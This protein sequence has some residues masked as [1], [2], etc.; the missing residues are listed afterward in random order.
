MKYL[1][2][3]QLCS[4]RGNSDQKEKRRKRLHLF[5]KVSYSTSD[6]FPQKRERIIRIEYIIHREKREEII[7]KVN[8][9]SN[10]RTKI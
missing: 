2:S 6:T 8:M 9:I 10:Q 5:I 4:K 3:S 7:F 1:A